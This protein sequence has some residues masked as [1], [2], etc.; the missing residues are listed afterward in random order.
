MDKIVGRVWKFGDNIN[1]DLIFPNTAFR[2]S[3]EEQAKLVFSA[4]RPGWSEEVKPGDIIVGGRNF[5]T[6]SSRPAPR[7][8]KQLKIGA[9]VANSING[10]FFRSS[11]NFGLPV[12]Q[13]PYVFE[14]FEE[15]DFAEIDLEAATVGNKRTGQAIKGLAIP[16]SIIN[17]MASGGVYPLLKAEGFLD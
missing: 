15:G 7:V 8:L 3:P 2:F 9:L 6:G 5:G 11:V 16:K 10:L 4:N 17:L 1:T 12:L 14:T 13:C